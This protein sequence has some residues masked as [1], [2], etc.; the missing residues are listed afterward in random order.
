VSASAENPRKAVDAEIGIERCDGDLA[1][2]T[3][4]NP[5]ALAIGIAPLDRE[6][7]ASMGVRSGATFARPDTARRSA[8]TRPILSRGR[9]TPWA[10]QG[11]IAIG[12]RQIHP[13]STDDASTLS[14]QA[15][16]SHL[17]GAQATV[18][19]TSKPRKLMCAC[20]AANNS[21]RGR[22]RV[23][24]TA[25]RRRRTALRRPPCKCTVSAPVGA[26]RRLRRRRL[27]DGEVDGSRTADAHLVAKP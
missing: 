4:R 6:P 18:D 15:S 5:C 26:V 25:P 21:T 10:P 1:G 7:Y 22:W 23:K 2:R 9:R 11:P 27:A 19:I 17:G 3:A 14:R 16:M 24:L 12:K 8:D 20:I 13:S